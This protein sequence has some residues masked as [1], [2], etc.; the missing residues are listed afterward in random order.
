M[1]RFNPIDRLSRQPSGC[2]ATPRALG[3]MEYIRTFSWNPAVI[4]YRV[5]IILH[6]HET[7]E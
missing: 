1:D 2:Q 5:R 7:H 3:D 6:P 4:G